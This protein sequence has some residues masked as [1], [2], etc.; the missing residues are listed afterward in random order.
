MGGRANSR[1]P[2]RV[3]ARASTFGSYLQYSETH[4]ATPESATACC[5]VETSDA[6]SRVCVV[7]TWVNTDFADD[8]ICLVPALIPFGAIFSRLA[9]VSTYACIDVVEASM[10]LPGAGQP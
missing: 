3:A 2:G 6:S 4:C 7:V 5:M 8:S 10:V 1:H 9:H